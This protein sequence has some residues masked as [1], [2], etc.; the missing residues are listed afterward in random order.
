MPVLRHRL[1][2]GGGPVD[3]LMAWVS[4]PDL[5]IFPSRQRYTLVRRASQAIVVRFES[6]DNPFVADIT[7]DDHGLVRD[8]PGLAR[9]I[10]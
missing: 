4:V 5:G 8:Y 1:L 9:G 6:L 10:A 2:S 7:F 3:L